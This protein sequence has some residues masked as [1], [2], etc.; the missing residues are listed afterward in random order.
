MREFGLLSETD[1]RL[2]SSTLE[3]GLYDD[4]ESSPTLESNF[5]DDTPSIDFHHSLIVNAESKPRAHLPSQSEKL[6]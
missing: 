1:P 4:Y 5:V 3:V 2:P 6:G